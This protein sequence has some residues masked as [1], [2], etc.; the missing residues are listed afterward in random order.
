MNEIPYQLAWRMSLANAVEYAFHVVAL[1]ARLWALGE[2]EHHAVGMA[3]VIMTSSMVVRGSTNTNVVRGEEVLRTGCAKGHELMRCKCQF[4]LAAIGWFLLFSVRSPTALVMGNIAMTWSSQWAMYDVPPAASAL[5][6]TIGLAGPG[7]TRCVLLPACAAMAHALSWLSVKPIET[8]SLSSEGSG[9]Q[10]SPM[11]VA[12]A[13]QSVATANTKTMAACGFI[14]LAVT[15]RI[16]AY[17]GSSWPSAR[18]RWDYLS[19]S[20]AP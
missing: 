1:L 14:V 18:P 6:T 9:P 19:T 2:G 20:Q 11:P 15:A 4:S 3:L 7:M 17:L 13:V 5:V 8:C 16:S 10:T 12:S